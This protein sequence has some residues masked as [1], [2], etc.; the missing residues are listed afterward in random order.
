MFFLLFF[1]QITFL[2]QNIGPFTQRFTIGQVITSL[3][4]IWFG[5]FNL[6]PFDPP[7]FM[8]KI[9]FLPLTFR[10]NFGLTPLFSTIWKAFWAQKFVGARKYFWGLPLLFFPFS[11]C[12]KGS[13]GLWGVSFSTFFFW[14]PW[15]FPPGVFGPS[16]F[17]LSS[18]FWG[19]SPRPH[20][21]FSSKN[22]VE[23]AAN[24]NTYWALYKKS[25]HG[26]HFFPSFDTKRQ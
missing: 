12:C 1:P 11:Q 6:F 5:I 16:G 20:G 9:S 14:K 13:F 18:Y 4:G 22:V 17:I 19:K 23:R 15:G 24:F 26:T 8:G 21:S 7:F 10:E 3:L 2:L 25:I